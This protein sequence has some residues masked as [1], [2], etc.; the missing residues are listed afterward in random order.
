MDGHPFCLAY[1]L[2]SST[3]F[4]EVHRVIIHDSLVQKIKKETFFLITIY[5]FL[6]DGTIRLTKETKIVFFIIS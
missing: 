5:Q 3:K 6:D 2:A 4:A 1:A